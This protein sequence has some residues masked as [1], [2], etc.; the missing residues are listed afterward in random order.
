L[1]NNFP[2]ALEK[3]VARTALEDEIAKRVLKLRAGG[4]MTLY[5]APGADG[6]TLLANVL[7]RR[8]IQSRFNGGIWFDAAP[9]VRPAA[10]QL[11]RLTVGFRAKPAAKAEFRIELFEHDSKG[12]VDIGYLATAEAISHLVEMGL[13]AKAAIKLG[14]VHHHLPRL[15]P[16]VGVGHQLGIRSWPR[17]YSGKVDEDYASIARAVLMALSLSDLH[18]LIDISVRGANLFKSGPDGEEL[19]RRLGWLCRVAEGNVATL[20]PSASKLLK[21]DFPTETRRARRNLLQ[22]MR[23]R[24]GAA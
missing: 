15:V 12:E 9:P 22:Y 14:S 19:A 2:P 20:D 1:L 17:L 13:P 3:L 5:A 11:P 21:T 24:K 10:L 18:A 23:K 16:L 4:T 6:S 7:R 8:T